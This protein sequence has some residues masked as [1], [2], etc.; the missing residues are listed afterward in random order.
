MEACGA[1]VKPDF[2][3]CTRLAAVFKAEALAVHFQNVDMVGQPIEQSAGQTFGTE[4]A[5]P[6]ILAYPVNAH[7]RYM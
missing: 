7:D 5:G 4:G 1:V 2:S 3:V 6:F